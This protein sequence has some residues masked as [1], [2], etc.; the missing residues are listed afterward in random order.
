MCIPSLLN[1]IFLIVGSIGRILIPS[2]LEEVIDM[3]FSEYSIVQ[4]VVSRTIGPD[5]LLIQTRLRFDVT[6]I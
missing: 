1:V 6:K 5:K 3:L 4:S 2:L